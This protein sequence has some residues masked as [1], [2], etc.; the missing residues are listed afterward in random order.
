MLQDRRRC[1][2]SCI[3]QFRSL[4]NPGYAKLLPLVARAGRDGGAADRRQH[5]GRVAGRVRDP[6][7]RVRRGRRG[8]GRGQPRRPWV[9]ATLAPLEQPGA[10]RELGE[11][12]VGACPVPVA[13][14]LPATAPM[15]YRRVA[16]E[17][18]AARVPVVVARNEFT[19]FEK[20]MLEARSAFQVIAIGEIRSGWD[21]SRALGKG[22]VA[23]QV[24]ATTGG[25]PV[26]AR[27]EREM[28]V[29]R[30]VARG[31]RPT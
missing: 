2:R 4:H 26:F 17:L 20:L 22:A 5:R 10:L 21:V 23:V 31:E 16:E 9:A 29:A 11:R 18:A 8:A 13:V 1:I 14:R 19:G 12:L 27:L 3:P 25:P 7:A 15:P 24:E 28:R 30:G 6:G